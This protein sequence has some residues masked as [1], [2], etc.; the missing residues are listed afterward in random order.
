MS[1][2]V[3][4]NDPNDPKLDCL[5]TETYEFWGTLI[6]GKPTSNKNTTGHGPKTWYCRVYLEPNRHGRTS[7]T[8][9]PGRDPVVTK[10]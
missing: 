5:S 1:W 10:V 3:P 8:L 7:S 4:P 2:G 9:S 6:F